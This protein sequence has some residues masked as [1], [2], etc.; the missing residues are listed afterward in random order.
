VVV[1]EKFKPHG[2]WRR[3]LEKDQEAKV[4]DIPPKMQKRFGTGTML[5]A[6]P[7]DVDA[8]VRK[9]RRGKLLTQSQLRAKLAKDYGADTC[10]PFTTGIFV[11]IVAETAEEDLRGGKKR[12][13]PY[14][15]V[16]MNDGNLNENFPGGARAQAKRLREENHEVE[17]SKGKKPPRLRDF[18]GKLVKL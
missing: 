9:V 1:H 10:C 12:V 17:P 4:V 7:L 11:R 8:L 16:I 3:K 18:E 15:R 5:I 2:T 13:T 6:K 14:W